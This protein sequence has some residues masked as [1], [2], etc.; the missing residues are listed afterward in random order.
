MC[1]VISRRVKGSSVMNSVVDKLFVECFYGVFVHLF[2][3]MVFVWQCPFLVYST[4]LRRCT[5]WLI[6]ALMWYCG[7]EPFKRLVLVVPIL[8]SSSALSLPQCPTCAAIHLIWTV[9]CFANSSSASWQWITVLLLV[10]LDESDC[11]VERLSVQITKVLLRLCWSVVVTFLMAV[12]SA[13][14][15]EQKSGS[16]KDEWLIILCGELFVV[17]RKPAPTPLSVRDP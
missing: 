11:R 3:N 9:L 17:V 2:P 8:A 12:T 4:W 10:S 14:N 5:L 7:M 16:L 6:R 15:T 1:P 13:W